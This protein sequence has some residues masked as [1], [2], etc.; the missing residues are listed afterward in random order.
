MSQSTPGSLH[1]R[2]FI[3][4]Q[5]QNNSSLLVLN[6]SWNGLHSVGCNAL[7]KALGKNTTLTEL[8]VASNRIDDDVL[9]KLVAGLN[10]NSTLTTLKVL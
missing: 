3:L 6:L 5:F 7:A 8:D 4:S 1:K 2:L 9:Q 10:N